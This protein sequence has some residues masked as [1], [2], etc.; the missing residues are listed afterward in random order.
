MEAG[1]PTKRWFPFF[2]WVRLLQHLYCIFLSTWNLFSLWLWGWRAQEL[3]LS[4]QLLLQFNRIAHR[5]LARSDALVFFT[6]QASQT[7]LRKRKLSLLLFLDCLLTQ[8][9]HFKHGKSKLGSCLSRNVDRV[10]YYDLFGKFG[11][12]WDCLRRQ[13]KIRFVPHQLMK[14]RD[15]GDLVGQLC[16]DLLWYFF[17]FWAFNKM[18]LP[19]WPDV[20]NEPY[21]LSNFNRKSLSFQ[22]SIKVI[23]QQLFLSGGYVWERYNVE[24]WVVSVSRVGKSYRSFSLYL[25]Y[26]ILF[27]KGLLKFNLRSFW[28]L[29]VLRR[30]YFICIANRLGLGAKSLP[31]LTKPPSKLGDFTSRVLFRVVFGY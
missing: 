21:H 13:S 19:S 23:A 4:L 3:S 15:L 20:L 31:V 9:Q 24:H 26:T 1:R 6:C 16:T 22:N 25:L 11:K 8:F 10:E 2:V 17:S 12:D 28:R 30:I 5:H 27:T 29:S 14:D 18:C 7:F